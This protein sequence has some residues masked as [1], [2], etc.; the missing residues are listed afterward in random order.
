MNPEIPPAAPYTPATAA[1]KE[2]A[3]AKFYGQKSRADLPLAEQ[4]R[5]AA[6][7]KATAKRKAKSARKARRKSR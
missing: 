3:F 6:K 1:E 5:R 2:R 7:S 4:K